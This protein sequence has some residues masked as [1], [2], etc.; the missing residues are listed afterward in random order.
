VEVSAND[1]EPGRNLNIVIRGNTSI[2]NS[3][4]PLYVVDGFP[5]AAGVSIAPED[6]ESIDILKDPPGTEAGRPAD[7]AS[8]GMHGVVPGTVARELA[9][10]GFEPVQS[11]EGTERWFMVVVRRAADV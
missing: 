2:S 10:A 11:V 8:D 1:G 6:I 7:R 3:N 5:M 4:Q 9:E